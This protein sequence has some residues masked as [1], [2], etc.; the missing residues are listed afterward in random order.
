M[1]DWFIKMGDELRGID[2]AATHKEYIGKIEQ[3][4]NERFI[5]SGSTKIMV[6]ALGVIYIFMAAGMIMILKETTG[7]ALHIIKYLLMSVIDLIVI[8]SLT[9]GKKKGEIV[10]F[11]GILIFV[12]GLFLSI[13]FS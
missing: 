2:S 8:F 9:F 12:S 6:I 11:V 5:F 7:A 10:S 13:L 4:K 3:K 1:F